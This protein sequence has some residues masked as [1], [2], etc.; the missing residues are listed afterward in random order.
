LRLSTQ[1]A[2]KPLDDNAVQLVQSTSRMLGSLT[3]YLADDKVYRSP[4]RGLLEGAGPQNGDEI[5]EYF[6]SPDGKL[7]FLMVSPIR[8][9]SS[10]TGTAE[11]VAIARRIVHRTAPMFPGVSMGVT[12]MPVLEADEML[13]ATGTGA[14]SLLISVVG[15]AAIFVAGFRAIRHPMFAIA[16]MLIGAAWTIGWTTLTIGHLSIISASFISTLVG[17]GVDFGIIWVTRYEADRAR[18]VSVREANVEVAE[19]VGVSIIVG[20][21]TTS[22][23]FFCTM[24]TG[25]LGLRE[26]GWIAG[27]GIVFCLI[28]VFTALPAMLMIGK[29]E[30]MAVQRG[31]WDDRPAFPWLAKRPVWSAAAGFTLTAAAALYL[32]SIH[33][34]Y[35]LLNLQAHGT[36]AVDWEMRLIERSGTSGW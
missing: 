10:F 11:P 13:A 21:L 29:R 6:L 17:M 23:A 5:P 20:A 9:K 2:D 31:A 16:T 33:F 15:V 3:D 18:G 1:P 35:N 7:A 22:A 28:A 27:S 30:H 12:G 8:D 34:D 26:M 32:P 36:P 14:T 4:W 24:F 19:S 25:F